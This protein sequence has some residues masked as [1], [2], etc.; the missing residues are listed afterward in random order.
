MIQSAGMLAVC[1]ISAVVLLPLSYCDLYAQRTKSSQAAGEQQKAEKGLK[2]N[3]QFMYF[4]NFSVSNGAVEQ[5]RALFKQAILHDKFA[6]F[7][8]MQFRF[9]NSF[10]Q[11]RKAQELL[12][13]LYSL[14]LIRH[15]GEGKKLLDTVSPGPILTNH[16]RSKHYCGLGYRNNEQARKYMIMADNYRQT[17]FSLRLYKYVQA[18]KLAKLAKRYALIAYIA[19]TYNDTEKVFSKREHIDNAPF[20]FSYIKTKL[21]LEEDVDR[22]NNL[23]MVLEDSYFRLVGDVSFY[24]V[25]WSSSSLRELPDY[26]EYEKEEE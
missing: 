2:D 3:E 15:I 25:V 11:I 10:Q 8:Y 17:L 12:I 6:R 20:M 22:R 1:L 24:D 26:L 13:S 14:V 5:E 19:F 16:H 7:L 21:E 23:L 18:L 9:K 4:I